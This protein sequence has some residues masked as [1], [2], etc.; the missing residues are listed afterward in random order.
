M[1]SMAPRP[2]AA[3]LRRLEVLN[4]ESGADCCRDLRALSEQSSS[5]PPFKEFHRR[6]AALADPRRLTAAT[7]L[8]RVGDMCGCELQAALGLTHATVSH[9]MRALQDAGIVTSEKRGKWIHYRLAPGAEGW[10]P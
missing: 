2:T 10:I 1:T 4:D 7:L 5:T 3:L 6:Y 8:K 9:H